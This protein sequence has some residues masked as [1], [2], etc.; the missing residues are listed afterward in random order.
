[1]HLI[2]ARDSHSLQHDGNKPQCEKRADLDRAQC[3]H[4]VTRTPPA[5]HVVSSQYV[6]MTNKGSK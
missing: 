6:V 2:T 3:S 5:T 4:T 1:M